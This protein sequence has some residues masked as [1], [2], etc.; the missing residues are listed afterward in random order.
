MGFVFSGCMANLSLFKLSSNARVCRS[1][2]SLLGALIKTKRYG[3]NWKNQA[4]ENQ[5]LR[6]PFIGHGSF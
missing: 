6:L 4:L 2:I 1:S 5:L 3:R